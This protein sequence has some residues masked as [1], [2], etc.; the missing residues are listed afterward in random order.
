MISPSRSRQRGPWSAKAML[1]VA[2]SYLL[3]VSTRRVETLA[4]SLGVQ[5]LSKSQVSAMA[6]ELDDMVEGFR[7]RPLDAGPYTFVRIDA[8][9]QKV[10]EGDRTVN[11]H[12]LIATGVNAA[13]YREI[14]G[15]DVASSEDG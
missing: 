8:L 5:G 7:S 2:T 9:T 1:V 14:L 6:A 13:G 12:A 4:A 11:A 3:G 15:I 10:R